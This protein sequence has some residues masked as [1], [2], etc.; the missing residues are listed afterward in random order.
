MRGRDL[1]FGTLERLDHAD[2][3]ERALRE[4]VAAPDFRSPMV[5]ARLGIARLCALHGRQD[6][7]VHLVPG[8]SAGAAEQDATPLRAITDF[9]E[10]LMY[11]LR[12][13]P[14]DINRARPLFEAAH[15]HFENLGMTGWIHRPRS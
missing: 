15:R 12:G 3:V 8:G 10:A 7:A 13:G 11:V 2:V 4:K 9:D 6:E 14:G 1:W 5:D